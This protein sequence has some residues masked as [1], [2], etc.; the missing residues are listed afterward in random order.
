M[1]T[2][3]FDVL[4]GG[5]ELGERMRGIDW[6]ATSLGPVETWPQSL[7]T[8]IRIILT[9]SQP[10]F[11]WW[12]DELIN[13]YNDA[14]IS[15]LAGKHPWALGKPAATVWGEIWSSVEPRAQRAMRDNQ[16]T[17]DEALLLVMERSGYREETYYTFSYSPVPGDRGGP[18]GILC[19]NSSDTQRIFGERQQALLSAVS[20]ATAEAR[21]PIEVCTRAAEAFD[22]NPRDLPFAVLYV[23][24]NAVASVAATTGIAAEHPLIATLPIQ[25]VIATRG[26]VVQPLA[27]AARVPT[28]PWDEPA[29]E[30]I[31]LP[32]FSSER[33][34]AAV[35]VV[36]RNPFRRLDD[37]Y[38]RFLELLAGQIGSSLA[39]AQAYEAERRRAEALAELDRA[40]TTFFSNIS[41]EFRTPLTLMIGPTEDALRTESRALTG[42]SLDAVYRNELRLLK[43]VNALLDFSRIEAGR[44]EAQ[45]EAIDI[46]QYTRE[47]ASAFRSAMERA[48]LDF[49]VQTGTITGPV[50]VD[51]SMWEKIVLNL[52]SNALKFTFEG[53]VSVRVVD[54]GPDVELVVTDTGIGIAATELPRLFERF[55]RVEGARSRTHEGSGIGLALAHELVKLH[56]G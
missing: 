13:L 11:V 42:E 1:A 30:T 21:T 34:L 19:A 56:Q 52:L 9:S 10:M 28:G 33:S 26:L 15:I 23:V 5:G 31:A 36:G 50:Y 41:H 8:C 40:K 17:F 2:E 37:D 44:V 32:I 27:A 4:A 16:G 7:R 53:S 12:G 55:H 22:S 38:R 6:A 48:G 3:L 35:L 18:G 47:L 49:E 45:Y 24:E 25:D 20:S 39:S 14:Y 51:R 29:T 43:L 54:R 46:A